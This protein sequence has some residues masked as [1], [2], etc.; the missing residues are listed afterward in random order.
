MDYVFFLKYFWR[1]FGSDGKGSRTTSTIMHINYKPAKLVRGVRW[2]IEYYQENASGVRQRVREYHNLNRIKDLRERIKMA[3]KIVEDLNENLLPTG[4]PFKSITAIKEFTIVEGIEFGMKIKET[5]TDRKKTPQTYQSVIRYFLEYIYQHEMQD[6]LI[7]KFSVRDAGAFLDYAITKK[8]IKG[9]TYNNYKG[10]LRLI[11]GVLKD[12]EYID[13]NPWSEIKSM[14]SSEKERRALMKSEIE[15]IIE[16]SQNRNPYFTSILLLIH[17]CF[18]RPKEIREIKIKHIDLK[19]NLIYIPGYS[20]K[21]KK[22]GYVTM[23]DELVE[24]LCSL[25]LQEKESEYYLV[26]SGLIPGRNQCGNNSL[27][28][29][30]RRILEDLQKEK[31]LKSIKGISIYSWKDT[32]ALELINRGID[33]LQIKN[34]MRHSSLETT[35]RYVKSLGNVSADIK[36]MRGSLAVTASRHLSDPRN[37]RPS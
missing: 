16:E 21:N 17:Y 9:S 11:F 13:T 25:N 12:R 24:F 36:N 8:G 23:P 26:G 1:I 18:I 34:Q 14:K 7:K 28:N 29:Y 20:S 31:V 33:I 32:G 19:S 4:Y 10:I 6:N 5:E 15:A 35:N 2:Y 22:S 3:L 37:N 27:N 30:H